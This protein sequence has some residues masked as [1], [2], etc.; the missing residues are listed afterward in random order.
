MP[1]EAQTFRISHADKC[2]AGTL[3][4][5]GAPPGMS[6]ELADSFMA[7]LKAGR[8]LRYLT[9]G[10]DR[11]AVV[12]PGRF[13]KHCELNPRWGRLAN[14]LARANTIAAYALKSPK[15]YLRL[16][17]YG[18]PL[19]SGRIYFRYGYECRRCLKC[20]QLRNAR[21][22]IIKPEDLAKATAALRNGSTVKQKLRAVR[23]QDG[24]RSRIINTAAFYRYRSENPD[25]NRIVRDAIEK[26]IGPSI[27]P[28]LAV[29][30]GTFKYEWDPTDHQLICGMLPPNFPDKDAV[31]NEV[32]ITLLEGRLHRSQIGA[33]IQWYIKAH[34]RLFPTKYAKF[35]D[36]PLDSL[37]EVMFEDG[38]ITRGDTVSRGLWD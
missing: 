19:D 36:S 12:T 13:K 29:A 18:H 37:D 11:P 17:K 5:Q 25:F 34:Y 24:R 3:R 20:D 7:E 10:S 1:I 23:E 35:G 33:K 30:A 8:T 26:R 21:A 28:V 16:C 38:S 27:N 14:K 22:G 31:I 15:L 9:S 32:I 2:R 4:W 6:T